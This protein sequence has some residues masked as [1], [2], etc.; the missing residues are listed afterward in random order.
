MS[1]TCTVADVHSTLIQNGRIL[2]GS[3]V[4]NGSLWVIGGLCPDPQSPWGGVTASVE[5]F[6]AEYGYWDPN[7]VPPLPLQTYQESPGMGMLTALYS[8]ADDKVYAIGGAL[9]GNDGL[10][11]NCQGAGLAISAKNTASSA[12]ATLPSWNI[13]GPGLSILVGCSSKAAIAGRTLFVAGY[14]TYPQGT[15]NT[16]VVALDVLNWN[17]G[18][19]TLA[20]PNIPRT[21]TSIV[22]SA[23]ALWLIGGNRIANPGAVG[24]RKAQQGP[25]MPV[26]EVIPLAN[27]S[28][29]WQMYP[30]MPGAVNDAPAFLLG[31]ASTPLDPTPFFVWA[32]ESAYLWN[33]TAS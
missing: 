7:A 14:N 29:S 11:A 20:Q 32:A 21:G 27:I 28:A 5:V 8:E 15:S 16:V 22:A 26:V 9:G 31:S 24:P 13:Y 12:W 10:D 2:H 1:L 23:G 19:T 33:S 18:W 6:N 4:V 3:V 17:A 25:G 30:S